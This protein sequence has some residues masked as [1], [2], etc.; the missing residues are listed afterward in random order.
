MSIHEKIKPEI[1]QEKCPFCDKT[2][3]SK[4]RLN[5]HI[6]TVH[7]GKTTLKLNCNF[8]EETFASKK[9][10]KSHICSVHEKIKPEVYEGFDGIVV[11]GPKISLHS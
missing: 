10:L 1:D 3:A 9:H 7:E 5:G 6:S 2:L 11:Q 4:Q 8:C